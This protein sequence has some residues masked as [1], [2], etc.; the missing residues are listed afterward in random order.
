MTRTFGIYYGSQTGNAEHIAS[1]ILRDSLAQGY[2]TH[3]DNLKDHAKTEFSTEKLLVIVV[4]STGDGDPPDDILKFWRW[5]RKIKDDRAFAHTRYAILGLGDTNYD[6]FCNTARRLERRL[7]G[8]GATSFYP[9]GLADDATGLEEVVDPWIDG[10]WVALEKA[11]SPGSTS[12][13]DATVPK[14]APSDAPSKGEKEGDQSSVSQT[15][16]GAESTPDQVVPSISEGKEESVSLADSTIPLPSILTT[17]E[18]VEESNPWAAHPIDT[19]ILRDTLA[20]V[21]ELTS[22]PKAPPIRCAVHYIMPDA[23]ESKEEG[24]EREELA[25]EDLHYQHCL[26]PGVKA[27]SLVKLQSARCLTTKDAIKRTL[28]LELTSPFETLP[29]DAIGMLVPSPKDLVKAIATRLDLP[30]DQVLR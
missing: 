16:N 8:L 15:P 14:E 21:N 12:V 3:C 27:P 6:N 23:E 28:H 20:N 30:L 17:A 7:I 2:N 19:Q 4:S 29:G 24:Q 22:I 5:L 26:P 11:L 9:I 18:T 10:L 25:P 13:E 1:T